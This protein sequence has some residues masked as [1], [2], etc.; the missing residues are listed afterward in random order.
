MG[1]MQTYE[2]AI[3]YPDMVKRAA[4]I[5][6][7]AKTT[8]HNKIFAGTVME[9]ITSDPG[10]KNGFYQSADDVREGLSFHARLWAA[11]GWS[12]DFFAKQ[13]FKDLGFSSVE[14]FNTNFMCN[15]FLPMDPNNLLCMAEK[16]QNGDSSR[17]FDHNLVRTL[18]NIKA[19]TY[20]M[21]ISHDMFFPPIDCEREQKFIPNSE[22]KVINTI[23]GHLGL[24]GTDPSFMVQVD[25]HLEEL[26]GARMS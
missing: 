10:W 21:P 18:R 22:L 17:L 9:A 4:P 13:R 8:L 15:Y 16:W 2:W 26:L 1:A 20:V 23:D 11:M 7:T 24:F 3:T 12:T 19:K 5:A 6:D 14:D 25:E